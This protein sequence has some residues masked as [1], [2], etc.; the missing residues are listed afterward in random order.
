MRRV[1]AQLFCH[2]LR[3]LLSDVLAIALMTSVM[4]PCM[5]SVFTVDGL[6]AHAIVG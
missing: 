4:F 1:C 5:H 2:E 6:Q 3:Q